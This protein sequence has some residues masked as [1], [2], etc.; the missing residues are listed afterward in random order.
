MQLRDYQIDIVEKVRNVLR[1]GKRSVLVQSP[2]GSGKTVMFGYMMKKAEEKGNTSWLINHRRELVVQSAATLRA[3]GLNPNMII[4]GSAA[5]ADYGSTSVCSIQSLVRR[6]D[7]MRKPDLIVWDEAHHQAAGSW[8]AVREWAK[9]A[10]HIGLTAT[11][12]RLDG[13]GLGDWFEEMVTGPSVG[14]LIDNGHLSTYRL[15]APNAADLRGVRTKM[16][17]WV[18]SD[19]AN[20]MNR[21]SITGSAV[22]HYKQ[23]CNGARAVV[24]C[25]NVEHSKQ[26]AATFNQQSIPARHVDGNTSNHERDASIALFRQG[27]IRILTNCDLFGEGLDIPGIEAAILLRPT[28]SVGLYLQQVGRALRAAPGK[29]DATILDHV[30]NA[31]RHGLPDDVREWSLAATKRRI[32]KQ[33]AAAS[34]RI[35]RNCFYASKRHVSVCPNCNTEFIVIQQKVTERSGQ[36]TE[37]EKRRKKIQMWH[38]RSQCHTMEDFIRLGIDKGY[39]NPRGW[40]YIQMKL[41]HEKA[42]KRRV[43]KW[44]AKSEAI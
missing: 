19:L 13:A 16:G 29:R 23:L 35:C 27:T 32:T 11:P 15:F 3:W 31:E 34:C 21:P 24:F 33:A 18:A 9:D 5:N 42:S 2:T 36:L 14:W 20:A 28:Q 4:A 37:V 44:G 22:E 30:G 38:E 26:V 7:K 43:K 40:A 1:S 10:T 41:K 17:D 39:K 8:K 12:C 6:M 25:C